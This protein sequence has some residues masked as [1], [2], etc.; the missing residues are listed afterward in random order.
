MLRGQKGKKNGMSRDR[1]LMRQ[2]KGKVENFHINVH[3]FVHISCHLVMLWARHCFQHF[4]QVS[5]F[6][7]HINIVRWV[8][9]SL[10][11]WVNQGSEGSSNLSKAK[12]THR[13]SER[14]DTWTQV[15]V[16]PEPLFLNTIWQAFLQ[17]QDTRIQGKR[18]N[19]TSVWPSG[20]QTSQ[21]V[22]QGHLPRCLTPSPWSFTFIMC[23]VC[24][25][26]FRADMDI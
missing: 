17:N 23:C 11:K 8:L 10:Y 3:R 21:L 2:G 13:A 9:L 24:P 20:L 26:V 4:A 6:K 16:I 12:H 14:M 25:S 18:F 19:R 7:A 5:S 15:C 1:I 22:S